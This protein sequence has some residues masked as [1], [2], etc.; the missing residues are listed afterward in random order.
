MDIV[1]SAVAIRH[2]AVCYNRKW[3]RQAQGLVLYGIRED[4][5][6]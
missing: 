2:R 1:M 4:N 5:H 3:R 6:G